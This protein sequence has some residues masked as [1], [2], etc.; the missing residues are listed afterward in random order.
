MD[1]VTVQAQKLKKKEYNDRYYATKGKNLVKKAVLNKKI[2]KIC[3]NDD[4]LQEII[5]NTGY[6]RVIELCDQVFH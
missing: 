6:D 5:R 4:L 3:L 1:Q 2:T